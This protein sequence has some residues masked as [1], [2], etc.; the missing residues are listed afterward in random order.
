MR[1]FQR[2][3]KTEAMNSAADAE[4]LEAE[5]NEVLRK[6]NAASPVARAAVGYGVALAWKIFNAEFPSIDEFRGQSRSLQMDFLTKLAKTEDIMRDK[7]DPQV[8]LGVALTKMYFAPL[9]EGNGPMVNRMAEQLE[10]L[11]REGALL[12]GSLP[13]RD[14]NLGV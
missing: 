7:N 8:A 14:G 6:V 9:I 5:F 4:A 10:P 12:L 2:R 3:P 13:P 11:N 1:W